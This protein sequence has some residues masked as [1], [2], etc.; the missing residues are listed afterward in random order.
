MSSAHVGLNDQEVQHSLS[1]DSST[2]TAPAAFV[3]HF[4]GGLSLRDQ[5]VTSSAGYYK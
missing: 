4:E 3:N 2:A 5:L 1:R